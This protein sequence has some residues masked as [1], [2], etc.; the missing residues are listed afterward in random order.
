MTEHILEARD[1]TRTFRIGAGM[2]QKK[3]TLRAVNGV[4]LGLKKGEVLG[5]VGESGCGKSTI[6]RML[7]GLLEPTSGEIHFDGE[8]LYKMDRLARARRIQPVFQDP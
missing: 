6:A 7:L 8:P 5:I 3:K 4:S 2:L 1:A